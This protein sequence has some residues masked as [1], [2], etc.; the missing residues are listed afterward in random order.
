MVMWWNF[1]YDVFIIVNTDTLTKVEVEVFYQ[2]SN[3]IPIIIQ[4]LRVGL[5]SAQT[6][7]S[8]LS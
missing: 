5:R 7:K 6:E 8:L 4:Q 2:T 3:F 1:Y